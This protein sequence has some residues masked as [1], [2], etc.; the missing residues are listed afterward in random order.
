MCGV[1]APLRVAKGALDVTPLGLSVVV[2]WAFGVG[3]W[4]CHY[5]RWFVG[6]LG[7][8][9]VCGFRIGLCCRLGELVSILGC[10]CCE[11]IVFCGVGGMERDMERLWSYVRPI[12]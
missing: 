9:F 2:V 8:W 1:G 4:G 3:L 6:M 10:G 12:V 5:V 7:V 11:R